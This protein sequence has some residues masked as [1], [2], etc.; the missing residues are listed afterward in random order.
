VPPP[1]NKSGATAGSVLCG[2]GPN[3]QGLRL[4]VLQEQRPQDSG[5]VE[6]DFVVLDVGDNKH[7][8]ALQAVLQRVT[9][10]AEV[11]R[12]IRREYPACVNVANTNI[13]ALEAAPTPSVH[14]GSEIVVNPDF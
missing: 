1:V 13:L 5:P 14:G 4:R 3:N 2:F 11:L 9:N 7:S 12:L 6:G 8:H 10:A